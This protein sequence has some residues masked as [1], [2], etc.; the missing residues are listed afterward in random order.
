MPTVRTVQSLLSIS[1]TVLALSWAVTNLPHKTLIFHD[2]E[3]PTI[4]FH[5]F[6]GLENKMLKF[7]YFSGFPWHVEP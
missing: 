7:H 4:K 2:F 3:G 5:D 6:R 1:Y